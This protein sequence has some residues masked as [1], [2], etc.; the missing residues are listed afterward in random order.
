MEIRPHRLIKRKKQ[1]IKVGNNG[2]DAVI[3]VQ[4]MTIPLQQIM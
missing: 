2:A 3:S 4:S 1:K